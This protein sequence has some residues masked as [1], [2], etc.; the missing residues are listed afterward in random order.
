MPDGRVLFWNVPKRALIARNVQTGAEEVVFDLRREGV[1]LIGGV[2]G[3]GYKL[4]PDGQML[5]FTSATREGDVSTS[6]L[7]IKLLG[8]GPSRELA[9]V[10]GSERL[11]LQDWTPD[12]AAV[13]FTRWI[14]KPDEPVSLWRVSIHGGDPQALGL[15]MVGVRDVSVHP[16]GARITFTAGWPK[17]ELWVMENFLTEK[18]R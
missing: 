3:R 11:L 7:T 15:S 10:S 6:S 1:D 17:N 14:A 5:A 18:L 8:G 13:I 2:A 4:S 9:R 12:G 16:E